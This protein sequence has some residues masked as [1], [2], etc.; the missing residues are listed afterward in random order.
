MQND[1]TKKWEDVV[2]R[3]GNTIVAGIDIQDLEEG[4]DKLGWVKK[5]VSELRG[6][7]AG[8]KIN[9]T[10]MVGEP[11]QYEIEKYVAEVCKEENIVAIYDRKFPEVPNTNIKGIP[12]AK[13]MGYDAVTIS[14]MDGEASK[15]I[16]L[17]FNE[18]GIAVFSIGLM[19]NDG[20]AEEVFDNVNLKTGEK[21]AYSRL[22]KIIQAGA[23]GIVLG[24][25]YDARHKY[26][27]EYK[28]YVLKS[29]KGNFIYLSPG[30]GAQ[31]TTVEGH[32]KITNE[33]GV[34]P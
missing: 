34:D 2:K 18:V 11:Q 26:F 32:I 25:T 15:T 4:I 21:L 10:F 27:L 9:P 31:G 7:I 29:K 19:S 20:F 22:S 23:T 13:K 1:F 24:A 6:H 30:I 33:L 14:Q 12:G 17:C 5:Y 16:D 3:R 8:F 28:D